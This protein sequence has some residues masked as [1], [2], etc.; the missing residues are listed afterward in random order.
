MPFHI[1]VRSTL[2]NWNRWTVEPFQVE[3][4]AQEHIEKCIREYPWSKP[5][6]WRVVGI[7]QEEAE[8][9]SAIREFKS[10]YSPMRMVEILLEIETLKTHLKGIN[11]S[12]SSV[13]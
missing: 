3:S 4:D 11:G 6:D 12:V 8:R 9:E 5:E 10:Y 7:T 1:E 13:P 2:C